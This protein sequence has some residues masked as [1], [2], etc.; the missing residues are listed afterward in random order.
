[1]SIADQITRLQNDST[2]IANAIAAKGVTVPSG[3]GYDDYA[4]L[5]ASISTGSS[6]FD[7]WVAD[8]YT[9]L[10]INIVNSYQKDQQLR[11][12]MTGTI[13]WGDGTT[14][15]VSDSA[16]TTHTH[17]YATTGK[18]RIDLTP[19]AGAVFYIGGASSSYNIMGSRG[20][21]NYFR[22]ASLYQIEINDVV[23]RSLPNYACYCCYGLQRAWVGKTFTTIGSS[24]FY[25]CVSLHQV[26]WEDY[27]TIT[28][29]SMSNTFYNCQSL[30]D[31]G[32]YAPGAV[33]SMS[34]TY[35]NDYAITE[36]TIPATVTSIGTYTFYYTYGLR[37]LHVLPTSVPTATSSSFTSMRSSVIIEVPMDSLSAYQ[38]AD[39]W[40]DW[41]SNMIGVV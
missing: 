14:E 31:H 26:I 21:S 3:S 36:I 9:H 20:S 8:G 32:G 27:T 39:Y 23:S 30:Q 10:W 13:N 19:N 6:G 15:T 28:S 1:M 4:T 29:T 35:R 18:Y 16:Y 22:T 17:T 24:I 41:A 7:D 40:S 33:T 5:I 38:A 37:Y 34:Q 2:A 25:N 12:R 11:M